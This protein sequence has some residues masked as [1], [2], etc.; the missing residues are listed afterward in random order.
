[1]YDRPMQKLCSQCAAPFECTQAAG[2]WCAELP[3]V[4]AMP[5]PGGQDC[6]CPVCLRAKLEALKEGSPS[7]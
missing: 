7:V 1:M 2:C 3:H 5:A 4:F 6:L